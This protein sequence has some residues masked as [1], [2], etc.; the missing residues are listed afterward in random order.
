M[1]KNI[2]FTLP[3]ALSLPLKTFSQ[4]TLTYPAPG[5]YNIHQQVPA[6][7]PTLTG[8]VATGYTISPDLHKLTRLDFDPATGT[9]DR[10]YTGDCFRC[11]DLWQ[12]GMKRV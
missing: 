9:I 10:W 8:A 6:L 3:A 1:F 7:N 5:I 2:A 11:Y 4:A 12:P